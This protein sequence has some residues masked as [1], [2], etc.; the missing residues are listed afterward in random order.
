MRPTIG[1]ELS[2]TGLL[3]AE[4]LKRA[5]DWRRANGGSIE[6][7][8]VASGAVDEEALTAAVA[9]L[10]GL[11][12]AHRE[13]L[14]EAD[15]WAVAT[16]PAEARKR[17]RALPFERSG[18][19]LHVAVADPDN[20]VLVTGLE[21]ATGFEVRLYATAEAVLE[22]LL[23]RWERME[24][25]RSREAPRPA[26]PSAEEEASGGPEIEKAARVLLAEALR[27]AADGFEVALDSR[28]GYARTHHFGRPALTRRLPREVVPSLLA[29]FRA[30]LRASDPIEGTS[31]VVDMRADVGRA[32]LQRV[33]LTESGAEGIRLSF[34]ETHESSAS[35]GHE[36][37]DGEV[38][39]PRCGAAV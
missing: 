26:P 9:R 25:Q 15:P 37:A 8:L 19:H 10:W 32:G 3:T 38:F 16:L 29:W 2:R 14:V 5:S 30:R 20:P 1:H 24:E 7:A 36:G 17:L 35:C 11:E 22:D 18:G 31:F 33:V 13:R 6:R 12:P 27:S 28:G 21:A 4:G 23:Y 34:E 39:C